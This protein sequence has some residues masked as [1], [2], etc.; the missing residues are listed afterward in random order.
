M[1]NKWDGDHPSK[2]R[3]AECNGANM[4][5]SVKIP[6][7]INLFWG[8]YVKYNILEHLTKDIGDQSGQYTFK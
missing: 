4:I 6:T 5:T 1:K 7:P 8:S 3:E 2:K